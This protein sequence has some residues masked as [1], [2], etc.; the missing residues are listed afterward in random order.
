M[1]KPRSLL[2]ARMYVNHRR[3]QRGADKDFNKSHLDTRWKTNP[4]GGASHSKRTVLEKVG[5]EATQKNS[6]IR[7]Y[8]TVQLIK[9][10]EKITAFVPRDRCFNHIK[11]NDIVLVKCKIS[12]FI[13]P[14]VIHCIF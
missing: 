6:A 7:K 3:E 12:Q 13:T 1:G 10:G 8:T 4:F 2:T 11:G 5:D 14:S 9:N